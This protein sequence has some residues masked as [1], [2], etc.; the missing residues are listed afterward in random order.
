MSTVTLWPYLLYVNDAPEYQS[1]NMVTH[2]FQALKS[3]I[4]VKREPNIQDT[5]E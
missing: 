3:I 5:A 2:Y 1:N 4:E